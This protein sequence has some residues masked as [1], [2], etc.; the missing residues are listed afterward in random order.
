MVQHNDDR[1]RVDK[2]IFCLKKNK[3]KKCILVIYKVEEEEKTREYF[4]FNIKKRKE[5]K[6]F[7]VRNRPSKIKRNDD[8]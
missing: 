1:S 5:K 8:V 7:D 6:K 2:I 3:I 4:F